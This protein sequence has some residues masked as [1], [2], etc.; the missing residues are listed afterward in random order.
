MYGDGALPQDSIESHSSNVIELDRKMRGSNLDL[1]KRSNLNF[2][3]AY[4]ALRAL[5]LQAGA[6][7]ESTPHLNSNLFAYIHMRTWGQQL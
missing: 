4:L 3:R 1:R 5:V 7:N 6:D 2:A